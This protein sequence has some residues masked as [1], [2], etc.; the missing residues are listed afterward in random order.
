MIEDIAA[1]IPAYN[2][3]REMIKVVGELVSEFSNIVV[4]DDGCDESYGDIFK[5]VERIGEAAN[6]TILH[7]EV[8][9]GKGAALK[10]GFSYILESLPEVSAVVTLDADGQHTVSDTLKCCKGFIDFE[11]KTRPVVFGCRDFK[12][13][14]KIPPRS[15]FGNRLTSS[16]LKLFADITLSDTQTGLRVFDRDI[17]RS[18]CAV[19]G[20]RYEFEMNMIFELH[21]L[22]IPFMEVPIE[23][24]YLNENEGS[25][26]NPIKDSIRIYKVFFKFIASSLGSFVVDYLLFS[27][28][29]CLLENRMPELY[30][31]LFEISISYIEVST[32]VARVCSGIFNYC[33]NR[34]IFKTKKKDAA[35]S[36]PRYFLLWLVQMVVSANA[37]K[38]L[39]MWLGIPAMVTKI[40]VDPILF[41][42]SYKVQQVWVFKKKD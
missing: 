31:G 6:I 10:T 22:G 17:L 39:T 7:H 32:V 34:M 18:L 29:V 16:L 5:E 26:F 37:V 19:P 40:I 24:I 38:Y 36:G 3:D 25:H 20:E 35:G 2:P 13:D 15:R 23:V 11:G 9:R 28:L 1:L 27:V 30:T 41:F 21:D 8:N 33:V 12:S 4:V 14:T 42:I